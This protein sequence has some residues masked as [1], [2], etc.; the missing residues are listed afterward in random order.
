MRSI[1]SV[2]AFAFIITCFLTFWTGCSYKHD[3]NMITRLPDDTLRGELLSNYINSRRAC[4]VFAGKHGLVTIVNNEEE[5]IQLRNKINAEIIFS[6]ISAGKGKNELMNFAVAKFEP[7]YN[8]IHFISPISKSYKR[9]SVTPQAIE[10]LEE[11]SFNK[12]FPYFSYGSM[13]K[14][15]FLVLNTMFDE[16]NIA[17]YD[18]DGNYISHLPNRLLPEGINFQRHHQPLLACDDIHEVAVAA[19]LEFTHIAMYS[20]KQGVIEKLWDKHLIEPAYNTTGGRFSFEKTH[21][22]GF[23]W[24]ELVN[25]KIYSVHDLKQLH[26]RAKPTHTYLFVFD[27]SGVLLHKYFLDYKIHSISFAADGKTFYG[28]TEYPDV[29]IVKFQLP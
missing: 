17:V 9:Y 7:E 5:I 21:Y 12:G 1:I 15:S 22:T 19:D 6:D 16:N 29:H 24:L 8:V 3:H 23:E 26:D 28:V 14:D 27:Y 4:L 18:F 20:I 2:L 13:L 11:R 10:L 25:E